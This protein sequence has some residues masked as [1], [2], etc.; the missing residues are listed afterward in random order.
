M[1][2]ES[3]PVPELEKI[4]EISGIDDGKSWQ[5]ARPEELFVTEEIDDLGADFLPIGKI[6]VDTSLP[7]GLDEPLPKGRFTNRE[8]SWMDFNERVLEQSMDAGLP[9]LERLWFSNIFSSNLDEF[10]MVRVSGLKRKIRAGK[11]K[12]GSSGLAPTEVLQFIHERTHELIKRQ[13]QDFSENLRPALEKA[14]IYLLDWEQLSDLEKER[15]AQYFHDKVFPVLTPLAVDPAHP[16]PY[17]SGL[18]L[19][20]AV[21]VRNPL[22]GKHH[23]ARLRVPEGL[24]RL[25]SVDTAKKGGIVEEYIHSKTGARFILLEQVIIAHLERLFPGMEIL[26][27]DM[28]RITRNEDLKVVEDDAENLLT[29]I[30][31]EL[32]RRRFGAV[33]RLEV[34]ESMSES[35][36]QFLV[37]KLEIS[38]GDVFRLPAP[39]DFR[40]F[41]ELHDLDVPELKFKP[42]KPVTAAGVLGK[43]TSKKSALDSGSVKPA[44]SLAKKTRSMDSAETLDIFQVLRAQDVLVHHPYD[45]FSTSVQH[46]ITQAAHDPQV[47]AIKQ[48]LYR[49]SGDSPIVSA[50]IEAAMS[51]KQVVA[52]VEIKARFDEKANISWARKLERAGVHVV[53]GMVGLKTHCKLSLAVR[54]EGDVLRRYCHIGT[55][56]YHPKTACGYEDLGLLTT[57]PVITQD[58][59]RLFNQLSGYGPRSHFRKLLV[60]PVSIRSGLIER[61]EAQMRNHLAGEEAWIGIKVNSI[62]DERVVD[63]LYR[64][65]QAGVKVDIVVRGICAVRPGIRGLSDNIRVR[66]ILGRFLE[67]SRI[68]AFGTKGGEEVWIGS[69]DLMHRNLD[70]R[71]EVLVQVVEREHA[72]YL[73]DLLRTEADSKTSS[74]HLTKHGVWKRHKFDKNGKP[75]LDIQTE[76]MESASA[77]AAG[78][79]VSKDGRILDRP[80]RCSVHCTCF[81][82][83][84]SS[85][86]G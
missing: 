30:E 49:T 41:N 84:E 29:A 71:V 53:Y 5:A 78:R 6:P 44:A 36:R 15:M 77:R 43:T 1:A 40:V 81:G 46:F 69:A 80:C 42:Y 54:K 74:W 38:Q 20:I 14:G 65:S 68:F 86:S 85:T 75:L 63:A 48:T 67:H 62:M 13:A 56:N 7:L 23:F 10:Y 70:R 66:S 18:S 79:P 82:A 58:V 11:T 25:I 73:A 12:V 37:E 3:A 27:A 2:A 35:T 76:L 83:A 28:F 19:N 21:A 31:A 47:L 24:P 55:G 26:E 33:V 45:S 72:A 52:V 60:A 51:G 50:L 61:I 17:I 34:T 22:S 59:L 32:S 4:S 9:L 64:A 8:L 39:L 16:F 57:N